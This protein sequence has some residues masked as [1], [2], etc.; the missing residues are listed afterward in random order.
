MKMHWL[1]QHPMEEIDLFE[2]D[3]RGGL[4]RE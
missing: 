3:D 1:W 4:E 2:T